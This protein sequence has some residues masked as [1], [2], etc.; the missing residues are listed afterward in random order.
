MPPTF[1][2]FH[3]TRGHVISPDIRAPGFPNTILSD[4]LLHLRDVFRGKLHHPVKNTPLKI[5]GWNIIMEVWK[6]M[7]LSKWVI[8]R[9]HVNL[10]GCMF[11]KKMHNKRTKA[12]I[13]KV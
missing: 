6:I 13:Y 2:N 12:Q 7:F 11:V 9:F 3:D 10:L 1:P 4:E 8:C 5:N